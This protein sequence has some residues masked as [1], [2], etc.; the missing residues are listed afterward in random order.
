MQIQGNGILVF[1]SGVGGL[2]LLYDCVKNINN[3]TFY[4]YGDNFRAPYGNLPIEKIQSYILEVFERVAFLKPKM[5]VLACNTATAT[6]VDLLRAK[7]SF[8]I[9]GIEPAIYSGAKALKENGGRLLML[10]TCATCASERVR[11]IMEKANKEFPNVKISVCPCVELARVIEKNVGDRN[12]DYSPFLPA[13]SADAVVLGCTHYSFVKTQISAF[14]HAPVFDG[15]QGAV[16][17]LQ[18]LLGASNRVGVGCATC[19]NEKIPCEKWNGQPLVTP[20]QNKG[21]LPPIYFLGEAKIYNA[22]IF[23]QMFV[24]IRK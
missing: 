3:E 20:T 8:P 14:Y 5:A 2:T 18:S 23:E 15:N 17:R 10:A 6:C 13:Q 11:I 16:K 19:E 24:N 9:I 22:N 4:Y 12:F 21:I 1:D 7:Y